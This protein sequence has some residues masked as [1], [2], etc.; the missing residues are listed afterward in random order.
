[1]EGLI[2][3]IIIYITGV[4]LTIYLFLIGKLVAVD[5]YRKSNNGSN[6]INIILFNIS[7]CIYKNTYKRM[8]GIINGL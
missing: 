3:A 4:I 5:K 8:E 6:N 2:A 1:M 7:I